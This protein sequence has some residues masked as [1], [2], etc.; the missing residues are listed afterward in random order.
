MRLQLTLLTPPP[1]KKDPSWTPICTIVDPHICCFGS[2]YVASGTLICYRGPYMYHRWP[3]YV[4][5]WTLICHHGPPYMSLWIFICVIMDPRFGN[6]AI[7]GFT[8]DS[9]GFEYISNVFFFHSWSSANLNN[10]IF[11]EIT[12]CHC[13]DVLGEFF[14]FLSKSDYEK[15][16]WRSL[17]DTQRETKS[18]K[19][20]CRVHLLSRQLFLT[21]GVFFMAT[22]SQIN[23]GAETD[24]NSSIFLV[25]FMYFHYEVV[26]MF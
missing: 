21:F 9:A 18:R 4:L 8:D 3:L 5:S 19:T 22:T 13:L 15:S 26:S 20:I 1:E 2:F 25:L 10:I 7:K 23:A 16:W 17:R 12:K 14:F 24:K 11:M 6:E